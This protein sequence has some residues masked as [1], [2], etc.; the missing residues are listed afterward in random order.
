MSWLGRRDALDW[1]PFCGCSIG[2]VD[3]CIYALEGFS[4]AST[5]KYVWQYDPIKNSWAEASPMS[6]GRAYC[7]TGRLFVPQSLYCWPFFVDV[8]GEVYDPNLNSWLEMP[9]DMGEGWPARQAGTKL[10]VTVDDDL[11]ALDPSNSVDSAKIKVCD[12]EGDTWKVVAGDVPIHDF[13]KS[14]STY[15]FTRLLEKLHVITKDA[16]HNIMVLQDDM[17]NEHV[18]SAFSQ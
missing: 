7:K 18:E 16:N 13:T 2:V 6:V 9:I 3:G 11:Y 4:R 1:M 17:Q 10:S 5:I 12:Y 14:E 15:L 8:G